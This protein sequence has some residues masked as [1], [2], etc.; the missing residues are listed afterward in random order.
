MGEARQRRL[1]LIKGGRAQEAKAPEHNPKPAHK[2][3]IHVAVDKVTDEQID[4]RLA[5]LTHLT[6]QEFLEKIIEAGIAWFDME[7]DAKRTADEAKANPPSMI[8]VVPTMPPGI[9]EAAK[10]LQALKTG[11][12]LDGKA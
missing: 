4:R 5:L 11:A 8:E 10:R 2:V 1:A 7:M 12:P 3:I 6:R 9:A